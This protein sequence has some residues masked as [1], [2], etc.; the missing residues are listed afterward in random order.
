MIP[1]CRT[2]L[3]LSSL[4]LAA[5]AVDDRDNDTP[6]AD[7]LV[8]DADLV[9]A[10]VAVTFVAADADVVGCVAEGRCSARFGEH[11]AEIAN[12]T[13]EPAAVVAVVPAGVV[14]GPACL[15]VDGV[16]RC[17]GVDVVA[18]PV[19]VGVDVVTVECVCRCA[20]PTFSTL[21]IRGA[22]LPVDAVVAVD[23]S[24]VFV[25][26]VDDGGTQLSASMLEVLA[27]GSHTLTVRAPRHDDAISAGFAFVVD[28]AL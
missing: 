16:E 12:A 14:S 4:H 28:D 22:A 21:S 15:T 11:A 3:L 19:V 18:A 8:I 9:V 26:T 27:P 24:D 10:G 17:V 6:F 2:L 23:G 7:D 1:S 25:G 13:V 5:C 20:A